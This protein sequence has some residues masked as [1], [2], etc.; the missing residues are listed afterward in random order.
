MPNAVQEQE[1]AFKNR[2]KAMPKDNIINQESDSLLEIAIDKFT[3]C[4]EDAQ[5]GEIIETTYS[6]VTESELKQLTGWN[7]NWLSEDLNE[8]EIF[9]LKRKDNADIQ[10][11]IALTKFERDKAIYVNLAESAPHN[12]GK[13]KNITV[14][15]VI[16][17]R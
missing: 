14:S 9:K 1:K 2:L 3:P 7:F 10:G 15:A 17:L 16:Y 11:L 5:T 13:D 12:L 6:L 4:L 8:T